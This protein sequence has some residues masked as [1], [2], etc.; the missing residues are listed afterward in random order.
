MTDDA[1]QIASTL[2]RT[3]L[4]LPLCLMLLQ[5]PLM[6]QRPNP[7]GVLLFLGCLY[8][9]VNVARILSTHLTAAGISQFT[10]RG[11]VQMRW[12]D[13]TAVSRRNRSILLSSGE[14]SII[15]PTESFY[16]T[17]AAV[18]YLDSHLPQ[19]LRQH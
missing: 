3:K 9:T 7:F 4:L 10:W 14:R 12:E 6:V 2:E 15:V 11:R 13:V 18:D 1:P 5:G 19:H 16:D 17:R 8:T